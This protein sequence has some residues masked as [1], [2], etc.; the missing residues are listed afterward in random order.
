MRYQFWILLLAL[1]GTFNVFSQEK[2][3]QHVVGKGE[4]VFKIAQQ[5]HVQPLLIYQLNPDAKKGINYKQ[6]L[7]IPVTDKNQ[8]ATI[9]ES[10]SKQK[11][12]LVVSKETVYG[13]A[14][15]YGVK[16]ID[17]YK[18]NPLLEKKGFEWGKLLLFL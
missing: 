2:Y 3:I 16:V 13:I 10:T 11:E 1:F 9:P 18:L 14:R 7:L 17:L 8:I 12:H 5:Y 4:T 15:Q 6:K